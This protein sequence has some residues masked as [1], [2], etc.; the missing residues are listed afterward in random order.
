MR[1][2]K[3]ETF[4]CNIRPRREIKGP[5]LV[6]QAGSTVDKVSAIIDTHVCMRKEKGL[7]KTRDGTAMG[8]RREE[9]KPMY[10]HRNIFNY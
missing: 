9:C 7:K 2:T 1:P 4:R 6:M 8:L 3:R 5:K 10:I